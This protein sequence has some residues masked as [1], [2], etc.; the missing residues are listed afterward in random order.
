MVALN[1]RAFRPLVLPLAP[2]FLEFSGTKAVPSL[3]LYRLAY[4]PCQECHLPSPPILEA[5]IPTKNKIRIR[6]CLPTIATLH[7]P[8]RATASSLRFRTLHSAPCIMSTH[9]ALMLRGLTCTR[10]PV[11][12]LYSL[13]PFSLSLYKRSRELFSHHHIYTMQV[14]P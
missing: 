12:F 2:D 4:N 9:R 8:L 11:A 1:P 10:R 14:L 6:Q 3:T 7:L 13:S 5:T